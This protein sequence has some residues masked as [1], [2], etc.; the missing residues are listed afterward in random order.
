MGEKIMGTLGNII[1]FIF[2]GFPHAATKT[3]V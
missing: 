2:G 3:Y 1:W